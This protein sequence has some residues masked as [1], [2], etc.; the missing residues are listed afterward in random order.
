MVVADE[1][2]LIG[3]TV[4]ALRK[5]MS[6]TTLAEH[7]RS[8]GHKWSQATVWSVEKG[9]RPLRFREALDLAH[10]FAIDVTDLIEGSDLRRNL[11]ANI[12]MLEECWNNA[13]H[14]AVKVHV[15]GRVIRRLVKDVANDEELVQRA[16]EALDR[17]TIDRLIDEFEKASGRRRG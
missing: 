12:A 4:A 1:D 5:S 2:R 16:H 15:T 17:F 11:K 9:E 14:M 8:L 7:M 3:Q 10:L 13:R 6:Q